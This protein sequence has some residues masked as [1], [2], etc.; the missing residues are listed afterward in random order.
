MSL[1]TVIIITGNFL[2]AL[3]LLTHIFP[4]CQGFAGFP[5]QFFSQPLVI[6]NDV[7]HQIFELHYYDDNFF[8]YTSSL[9]HAYVTH[10][11]YPKMFELQLHLTSHFNQNQEQ[12]IHE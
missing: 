7:F 11:L 3:N 8:T 12:N 10:K 1:Q 9:L 5:Y 4:S 6:S 2:G